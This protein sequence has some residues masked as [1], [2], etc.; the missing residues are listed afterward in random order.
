MA[1]ILVLGVK[2]PYTRGGQEILVETLTKEIRARGH[3]VDIIELPFNPLP[4]ENLITAAAMWRALDLSTFAGHPIDLVIPTKFPSYYV[5]HPKKSVWLVHQL[6]SIYDLYGGQFSDIGDDPRDEAL[7]RILTDGDTQTLGECAFRGAISQTVADR[8]DTFNG[9]SAEVLYPP[10][11]LGNRYRTA[12]AEPYIL[13][14]GR[15]C[16]IKRVELMITA[17][18]HVRDL[19]LKVV[20][21]PDEPGTL[22]YLQNLVKHYGVIPR[23][24]FLGRVSEE[25]L[26]D[27]HA[28]AT[29]TF[30]APFNE[31]YGYVTIEAMASGKPV[32]TASDSGGPLEFVRHDENGLVA[33]PTPES[34]GAAFNL[35][36]DDPER[37]QDL[38]ANGRK[39]IESSGMLEG[40]WDRVI[41]RLLSP[42]L[43]STERSAALGEAR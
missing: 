36:L 1:R 38:G 30:Y 25:E 23:V 10:L 37:A 18:P 40:G 5:R 16:R 8:L 4:K 29:A 31:D 7:R 22:D 11:P 17:L 14:V 13:S 35:L 26:L 3:E 12:P 2:V 15:L 34:I 42:L 6:R 20:G 21:V 43:S 33:D 24:D 28:R 41:D 27:L 19:R 9:L 39:F 32:V